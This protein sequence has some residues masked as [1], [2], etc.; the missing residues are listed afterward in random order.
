MIEHAHWLHD[1]GY[2]GL[3]GLLAVGIFGVPV[4]D[5]ALLTAAGTLLRH[6]ELAPLPILLCAVAGSLVG[7]TGSYYVGRGLEVW[8]VAGHSRLRRRVVEGMARVRPWWDRFGRWVLVFGYFVP[9]VRHFTG[10]VA[11][12]VR[13]PFRRFIVAA[14]VGALCWTATFLSLGYVLN[15]EWYRALALSQRNRAIAL[16][17]GVLVF[18]LGGL[19]LRMIRYRRR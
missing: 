16:L 2:A 12:S 17:A 5:E 8:L 4:P 19:I 14:G 13:L 6:G 15:R 11:G 18:T 7:I 10:M 3:F 9:G 1:Y